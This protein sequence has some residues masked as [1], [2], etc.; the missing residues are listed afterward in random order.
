MNPVGSLLSDCSSSST[1]ERK[2]RLKETRT[3]NRLSTRRELKHSIEKKFRLRY[4]SLQHAYEQ[5][6]EVLATRMQEA[7]NQVHEDATIH[8]LKEN[9]LTSEYASARLGEIVHECFFGDRERY[10]K[11][12]SDQIAWQA[13]DLREAQQKLKILQKRE[14]DA[15]KQW[16]LAQRDAE[17]QHE[18]LDV[19]L[20]ELRV[21]KDRIDDYKS[22]C[23]AIAEERDTAKREVKKL[24]ISV[25]TMEKLQQHNQALENELQQ[26]KEIQLAVNG[27]LE[28]S[29][30]RLQE[31]KNEIEL[32]KQV[33]EQE[34]SHLKHLL[35][36]SESK[37]QDVAQT[38]EKL[39]SAEYP[40]KLA[41]LESELAHQ[42]QLTR[43][44]EKDHD[45][46]KRR[47]Q[48]FGMQVEQYMKEQTQEKATLVLKRD[49]QVKEVRTELEAFRQQAQ[50]VIKTKEQELTR[51]MELL[52]LRHEAL[53]KAEKRILSLEESVRV[54][55][56]QEIEMK[57][58]HKKFAETL[59]KEIEQWRHALEKEQEKVTSLQKVLVETQDKYERKIVS[60]QDT[61]TQQNRQD[62]SKKE[63][64]ARLRWQN[65]FVAKQDARMDEL[66]RKCDRALEK[67]EV[68]LRQA[69]Q[70]AM[71]SANS[72]AAKWESVKFAQKEEK[73]RD[74]RRRL[75]DAAREKERKEDQRVLQLEQKRMQQEFVEREKHLLE[76]ERT[77]LDREIREEHRRAKDAKKST[78]ASPV[79]VPPNV[80][81]L[82]VN[83]TEEENKAT[84]ADEN[85]EPRIALKQCHQS[86]KLYRQ[87]QENGEHCTSIS[88]AQHLAELQT[89]EAQAALRAEERVQKL[90]HEFQERKES[91]FRAAMVNV[92]KGIQKLEVSLEE[93]KTDRKRVE[94]QLLSERQAFVSLK[95]EYEES[96]DAK[97]TIVQRL[98][99]ANENVGRLRS[100]VKELQVQCHSLDEQCQ[101]ANVQKE[102]AQAAFASSQKV[103]EQLRE[104]LS[105]L[106]EAAL[107]LEN[108]LDTSVESSEQSK[109]ELLDQIAILEHRIKTREEQFKTEV[110]AI[111]ENNTRELRNVSL[112]YDTQVDQL[113]V[114]INTIQSDALEQQTK[115]KQ[116]EVS[117][118]E[119]QVEKD[120]L[121][122]KVETMK[123][124]SL[125]QMKDFADL[126]RMHKNLTDSIDKRLKTAGEALEKERDQRIAIEEQAFKT[127][128][129]LQKHV[130]NLSSSLRQLK[131]ECNEVRRGV[132]SEMNVGW[133]YIEKEIA[134]ACIEWK[135]R[136]DDMVQAAD[137]VWRLKVE[138][139]KQEWK[140]C[141][142][143]KDEQLSK[144]LASQ[145]V[146]DQAK[147]DQIVD[148]L[149]TKARELEE[150]T[151]RLMA[152]NELN[153]DL[154]RT[155]QTLEEDKR[156]KNLELTHLQEQLS[157]AQTTAQKEMLEKDQ[158]IALLENQ[159][160]MCENY[161]VFYAALA[162]Q[163]EKDPSEKLSNMDI[164]NEDSTWN[165]RQLSDELTQLA[166]HLQESQTQAI[167]RAIAEVTASSDQGVSASI[168]SELDAAKKALEFIWCESSPNG[169]DREY[170][171]N[172]PWYIRVAT[173]VER[174]R[175]TNRQ[176]T[177]T[178]QRDLAAK[179]TEMNELKDRKSK[180]VE[181]NNLLRFENDTVLREMELLRQTLEKRKVQELHE[182]QV[183]YDARIEQQKQHHDRA[184]LKSEQ[185]NETAMNQLRDTLKAER[186]ASNHVKNELIELKMIL[187]RTEEELKESHQKLNKETE[188]LREI[189]NKWKRKA[190]LAIKNT[191]SV[192][193][194]KS[195]K[196][197]MSASSF[198][199]EED[200]DAS[201]RMMHPDLQRASNAMADL[202]NLMEQSLV[203]IRNES[204]S[205]CR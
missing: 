92:R 40:T 137:A 158:V 130:N 172:L 86:E 100:V 46:L 200:S 79:S 139:E 38:L 41:R 59:E 169:N 127:K 120:L 152:Q 115:A 1:E 56:A 20:K 95:N 119:V 61:L 148:R 201:Y 102:E 138:Q 80:V 18:H 24:R 199:T 57:L 93:A 136:S 184:I 5:R 107:Q 198:G 178:I 187:E 52:S 94:E 84:R 193:Q 164:Q 183:E 171:D 126:S 167:Q 149:E 12:M 203:S 75:E 4:A 174:E 23:R 202:S 97:R 143:E 175:E 129:D 76:R 135:K 185:D 159:K 69:R 112:Q 140:Q 36:L 204:T 165:P 30:K 47:Y 25:Q 62:V 77:L 156:I 82:N 123:A 7:V 22:Q 55:N 190:K 45:D 157:T 85:V 9:A 182:L 122:I 116:L 87:E 83:S 106:N 125:K 154:N 65:E 32:S 110:T 73:E 109:K 162:K 188:E 91:E 128:V 108:S 189:A 15:Q 160:T 124:E 72:A 142:T 10:I 17:T 68:E 14:N 104:Q 113:Q 50:G 177:S 161:R 21:Q 194:V 133:V 63:L 153:T 191:G 53:G 151:R 11:A 19:R 43:L 180:W 51:A 99:E 134:L 27:E 176:M 35:M 173:I 141:L 196:M 105:R 132:G 78:T 64:E 44:N 179:E 145:R 49:E 192:I 163:T 33:S 117:M 6:L 166:T 90:M 118:R 48:E 131:I 147:Y 181:A 98:E 67:Q 197:H 74:Q 71:E 70:L 26:E 42:Q 28:E 121:Q 16:K 66:K 89:K 8:C 195:Q 114:T 103:N 96:K 150:A 111:E 88:M 146:S 58:Q 186:K 39:Q 37:A 34:L 54:T 155:I 168:L 81:V 3:S 170:D 2:S 29:R 144:L 31:A 205:H 60:I 101:A 13:S